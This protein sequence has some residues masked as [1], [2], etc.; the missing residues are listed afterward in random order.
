MGFFFLFSSQMSSC[1]SSPTVP[2]SGQSYYFP[3]VYIF[4]SWGVCCVSLFSEKAIRVC[5]RLVSRAGYHVR[6]AGM[7]SDLSGKLK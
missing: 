6:I 3:G 2:S 4:S 5:I 7:L 1:T